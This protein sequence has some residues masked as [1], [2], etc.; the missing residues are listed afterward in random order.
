[1]NKY[2][3]KTI[4]IQFAITLL[5][6]GVCSYWFVVSHKENPIQMDIVEW[7]FVSIQFGLTGIFALISIAKAADKRMAKK[8]A[9]ASL[10]IVIAI[11]GLLLLFD[12]MLLN[13]LWSFRKDGIP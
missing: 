5:Y 13:W 4:A 6:I 8:K 12:G 1:M 9:L 11:I 3:L 7:L 10:V 2:I